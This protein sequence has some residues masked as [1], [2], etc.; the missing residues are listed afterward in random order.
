[1]KKK[2]A[3]LRECVGLRPPPNSPIAFFRRPASAQAHRLRRPLR[4]RPD[5]KNAGEFFVH[6]VEILSLSSLLSCGVGFSIIYCFNNP[7]CAVVVA[8]AIH[9][10]GSEASVTANVCIQGGDDTAPQELPRLRRRGGASR[11]AEEDAEGPAGWWWEPD[12]SM[13]AGRVGLFRYRQ[14]EGR[15]AAEKTE[16]AGRRTSPKDEWFFCSPDAFLRLPIC[17]RG[18][19][20][21]EAM[22]TGGDLSGNVLWLLV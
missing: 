14:P 6:S 5:W 13:A 20:E 21:T 3:N 18:H 16:A 11:G 22:R 8:I 10:V 7:A 2:S 9:D 4:G 1:M 17:G 19:G 12:G 15:G